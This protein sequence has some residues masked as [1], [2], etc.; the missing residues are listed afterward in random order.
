MQEVVERAEKTLDRDRLSHGRRCA[1][2][3]AAERIAEVTIDLVET[4]LEIWCG[5]SVDR[6]L[7]D[8]NV[9]A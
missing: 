1:A 6:I 3:I 7:R 2:K 5:R 9:L 8:G 4:S